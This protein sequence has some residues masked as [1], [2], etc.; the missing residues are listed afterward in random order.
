MKA[1]GIKRFGAPDVLEPM[2]LPK[3]TAGVGE[4]LIRVAATSIN[5]VDYKLRRGDIP[6]LVPSFPAVL[7]PD[8]AGVVEAVGEGV[9][10]FTAGDEVWAFATG[11]AGIWGASAEYMVA[12]SQM[13][14]HKPK[15]LSLAEAAVMPLV[16]VTAWQALVEDAQIQPGQTVLIHGGTGGVGHI[17]IQI[18][19]WRGAR[20]YATCGTDEK[21]AI[22][23]SLG[24]DEAVNYN[25]CPVE[26]YVEALTE[27][28]GFDVVFNTAGSPAANASLKATKPYGLVLDINGSFPT[29]PGF[30]TKSLHF[31]SIF[32][33]QPI[34][35]GQRRDT[36]GHIL[37]QAADLVDQGV[38]VPVIDEHHFTLE[39]IAKAHELAEFG[40]PTGKVSVRQKDTND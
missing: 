27:D 20:V 13:I 23:R 33:G 28:K 37:K 2:E 5:P 8:A 22:A 38:L 26:S 36:I 12:D 6:P 16:T 39:D 35:S 25:L 19:K 40:R 29:Q 17:A 7:H 32:A 14:S 15:R 10:E 21:C 4:V 24:A 9:A 11:I 18:A 3:P 34:L 1:Y 31:K 30:L